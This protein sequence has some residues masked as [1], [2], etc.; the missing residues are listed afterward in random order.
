M[1]MKGDQLCMAAVAQLGSEEMKDRK[2]CMAAVTQNK[3]QRFPS[4]TLAMR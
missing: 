4:P 2:L 1:R 3:I